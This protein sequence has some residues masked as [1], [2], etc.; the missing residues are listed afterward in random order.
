[1]ATYTTFAGDVLDRICF[2][3]YGSEDKVHDV[4]TANPGLAE[5]EQPFAAGV[6][7]ILPTTAPE[8]SAAATSSV[9]LWQ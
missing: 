9:R 1:M 7:I 6:Q 4:L 8:Q 5:L 2:D 3:Y